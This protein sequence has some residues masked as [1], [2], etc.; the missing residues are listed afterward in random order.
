MPTPAGTGARMLRPH[1]NDSHPGVFDDVLV[2]RAG[3]RRTLRFGASLPPAQLI[4]GMAD[5][6]T[7]LEAYATAPQSPGAAASA[8]PCTSPKARSY[9]VP[10]ARSDSFAGPS[11]PSS[12]KRGGRPIWP[13]P[14]GLGRAARRRCGQ[15][16]STLNHIG[17]S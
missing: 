3:V 7:L 13:G 14:A 6:M 5:H 10:D 1:G 4:D 9:Q 8:R 2:V 15:H 12:S 16:L 17:R 11:K